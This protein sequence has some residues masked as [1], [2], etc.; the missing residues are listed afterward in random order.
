MNDLAR[1]QQYL[2]IR[3][4]SNV[5]PEQIVDALNQL[6]TDINAAMYSTGGAQVPYATIAQVRQWAAA[7][8][9][10]LYIYTID[11]AMPADIAQTTNIIWNH[12][13]TMKQGDALYA[14]IQSTLGFS[15]AQMLAALTTMQGY[16]P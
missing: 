13:S 4:F 16:V 6:I 8:G 2:P 7:N 15:S 14:F 5:A 11:N 10:P 12:G 9:S 3:G 1:L